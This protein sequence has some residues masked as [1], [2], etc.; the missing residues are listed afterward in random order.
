[1]PLRKAKIT[2]FLAGNPRCHRLAV[3]P[4]EERYLLSE[5]MEFGGMTPNAGVSYITQGADGNLWFT[6][7]NANKVGRLNPVSGRL[8]EFSVP[9]PGSA[10]GGITAGP[11]G[12]LWF[13]EVA[14]SSIGR[15]T[16]SGVITKFRTP[17][18]GSFPRN[19]TAGADGRLWFTEAGSGKVGRITTTGIVTEFPIPTTNSGL[20]GITAGPDGNLWFTEGTA[21]R[22]G[23]ITTSGSVNEFPTPTSNSGPGGIATGGDGN[24]WFT[25]TSAS[26]LGR[27]TTSGTITAADEFPTLVAFRNPLEIAPGPDG[28]MWFTEGNATDFVSRIGEI[29]TRGV[30]GVEY[31]VPSRNPAPVGITIG[32]HA[33]LAFAEF[34][35]DKIGVVEHLLDDNHTF[36]QSLYQDALGRVAT[37]NE[38]DPWV[39]L[40]V[41]AGRASVVDGIEQ[42]PEAR[43]HLLK[44]WYLHFLGRPAL[45]GEEQGF[46]QLLLHGSSESQVLNQILGS[47][48]YFNHAPVA[49]S[50]G[51]PPTNQTFVEALYSQLLQRTAS[52]NE[53]SAWVGAIPTLS[54]PGVTQQFLGSLEYRTDVVDAYYTGLLHRDTA[55]AAD[56]A[57][58][59]NSGMSLGQIRLAFEA[60]M[61]FFANG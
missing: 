9:T 34:L 19:I 24:L 53:V 2:H 21:S 14:A 30:P 49:A 54:L 39:N 26:K 47:P 25:E 31:V 51:G 36:V 59:L 40:L 8:V 6:E 27:I 38:L 17:T 29:S 16:T 61:E 7:S 58:W 23:R 5:I 45:N 56:V 11:D 48:E 46:V 15:I 57:A 35:V 37:T 55:P 20:Y 60:C 43:T 4:L 44:G 28:N 10:P 22:I 3:E 18:E 32:P 1:M 42:S 50:V 41:Q 13:T 33:T 52:A 12:N